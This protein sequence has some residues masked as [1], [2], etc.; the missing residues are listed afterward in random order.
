MGERI[1]S[2]V[3]AAALAPEDSG[4]LISIS[5]GVAQ[6]PPGVEQATD[7]LDLADQALYRA[8]DRGRNVVSD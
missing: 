6:M 3:E 7:L 2:V 4:V 1:R 5:I 8:K